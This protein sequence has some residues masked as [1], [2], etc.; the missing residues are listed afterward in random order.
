VLAWLLLTVALGLAFR[1]IR[2]G[3]AAGRRELRVDN[4]A[5]HLDVVAEE[6]LWV[7]PAVVTMTSFLG[8][9]ET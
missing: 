6:E 5:G 9:R 8:R 7:L 4:P 3:L 2:A 1:A